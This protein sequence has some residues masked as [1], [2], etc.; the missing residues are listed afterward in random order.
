MAYFWIS[1]MWEPLLPFLSFS[2]PHLIA[3]LVFSLCHLSGSSVL[4]ILT[5]CSGLAGFLSCKRAL[6][7]ATAFICQPISLSFPLAHSSSFPPTLVLGSD[8]CISIYF[9]CHWNHRCL[10]CVFKKPSSLSSIHLSPAVFKLKTTWCLLRKKW[11]ISRRASG[12]YSEQKITY[13]IIYLTNS[14]ILLINFD[15][16]SKIKVIM[17]N[18]VFKL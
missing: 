1:R 10:F 12:V 5:T 15:L 2:L 4:G 7:C 11:A 9:L 17:I 3:F 18:K 6:H 14:C 16:Y 13:F 8:L